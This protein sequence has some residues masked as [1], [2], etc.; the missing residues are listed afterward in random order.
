MPAVPELVLAAIGILATLA[1][2]LLLAP[3][4]VRARRRFV[5]RDEQEPETRTDVMLDPQATGSEVAVKAAMNNGARPPDEGA[6]SVAGPLDS[7]VSD[8]GLEDRVIRMV[9]W[10]FLMAVAVFAAASG[11]WAVSLPAIVILIA[12]T[13]QAMLVLQDVVP[14]TPLR[15]ARGPLQG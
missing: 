3:T 13:G 2:A 1:L 8:P 4:F 12:I 10:A 7:V 9:S 6:P 5:A 15:A 14:R 11:L